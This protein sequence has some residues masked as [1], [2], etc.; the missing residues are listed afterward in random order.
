MIPRQPDPVREDGPD[1][2]PARERRAFIRYQRRFDMLWQLLGLSLRDQ[3]QATVLDVSVN[4]LGLSADRPVPV[5]ALVV[6]RLPTV[7]DGWTSHLVRIKCCQEQPDGTY[8]VGCTFAR[9][10]SASQLQG[11]LGS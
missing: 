4:G 5:E 10:L 3:V 2:P 6:V 7:M 1:L 11:L 8:R 9:P